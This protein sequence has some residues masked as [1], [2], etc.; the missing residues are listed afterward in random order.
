[1]IVEME[2][3]LIQE[4]FSIV[5]A[6][7]ILGLTAEKVIFVI[8]TDKKL[9]GALTDGD[10]RRWILSGGGLQDVIKKVC[11]TS[12]FTVKS[13]Y[14]MDDIKHTMLT[15]RIECIP[16]VNDKH[17]VEDLL[18]WNE[19]FEEK[20]K[21]KVKGKLDLPVVIMAG[22]KGTRLDPFTRILPKPLIPIG[23]KAII[24]IIIDKFLEYQIN[25]YYI[26]VNVKSKIIK[27]YFEELNPEYSVNYIHESKPLGTAG[28]LKYLEGKIEGDFIVTNCDIIID[29]DYVPLVDFHRKNENDITVVAS[30]KQYK[31]PYGVCEVINGGILKEIIEKP[32]YDLLVN[33]G[34]Y[35]IKSSL[36][37][38]IGQDEFFHMTHFI[39]RVQLLGKKVGVFPIGEKEWIDT[40]EWEEYKNAVKILN[41]S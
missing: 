6:M 38:H 3:Y 19:V 5:E 7:R 18:F 29:T 40:G 11:N 36:L 25:Q 2:K 20:E 32:A 24:E 33:T 39:E 12:P 21:E 35:V 31:I 17:Q 28:S 15:N 30:L 13:D 34:M 41:L 22:G 1:M 16:V 9:L 23:N 27:S 4:N 10:I 14:N 8:N 26:S 37:E